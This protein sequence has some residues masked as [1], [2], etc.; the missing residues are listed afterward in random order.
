M[1]ITLFFV[2]QVDHPVGSLSRGS[3]L[4]HGPQ[5]RLVPG[6]DPGRDL[7]VQRGHPVVRD[8]RLEAADHDLRQ[9]AARHDRRRGRGQL[10]ADGDERRKVCRQHGRQERQVQDGHP[11]G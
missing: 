10:A 8:L 11:R 1:F 2:N 9:R 5:L 3:P 7:P 4:R 6:I